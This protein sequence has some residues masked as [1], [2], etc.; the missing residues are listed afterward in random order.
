MYA[1][2]ATFVG[3]SVQVSTNGLWR[4]REVFGELFDTHIAVLANQFDNGILAILLIHKPG[5][6]D[7]Y[8]SMCV[9]D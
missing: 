8:W 9:I 2:H 7:I 5:L 4:D 3:Q 6:F 1:A